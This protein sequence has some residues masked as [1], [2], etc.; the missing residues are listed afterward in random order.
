ME[1]TQRKVVLEPSTNTHTAKGNIEVTDK[2]EFLNTMVM[3]TNGQMIVEHSEHAT[4]ATDPKSEHVIKIVQSEIS[5]I[6][7]AIMAAFD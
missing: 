1:N 5:P 4:V 7:Q 3:K 6:S 2:R